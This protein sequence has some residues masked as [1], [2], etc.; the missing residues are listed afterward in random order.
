MDIPDLPLVV[1]MLA[2]FD[3]ERDPI[4]G[5]SLVIED[6]C[7]ERGLSASH[8]YNYLK[9]LD[10]YFSAVARQLSGIAFIGFSVWTSNFLTTLLFAMHLKGLGQAPFIVAGGPQLTESQASASL[11]LLSGLIDQVVLGEGEAT[12]LDVYASS[13]YSRKSTVAAVPGTMSMDGSG[14]LRRW[15]SRQLLRQEDIPVPT[16]DQIPLLSYQDSDSCT[17]PYHLSRGCTDKCVFCSEWKFWERFRPGSARGTLAGIEELSRRYG[18]RHIAFTDSLLNGHPGRLR[19]LCEGLLRSSNR[20]TWSGFMRAQMDR[21]TALLLRKAGCDVVFV[22]IESLS[23]DTLNLMNK[24]RTEDQNLEALRSFLNAGI[25]VVIGL[26]P[27]FPG[28]TRDA[29]LHT[30]NQVRDLQQQYPRG[31]RVNVEPFIVSPGQPIYSTLVASGL[32]GVGWEE[33]VLDIA[34]KYKEIT[35]S[36]LCRVEGIN[37]GV[38]RIGR[39]FIAESIQSDDPIR[40]D[41]FTYKASEDLVYHEF[42]FNHLTRGWF[43]ARAKGPAAWIYALIVNENERQQILD[44]QD[45]GDWRDVGGGS[46][47]GRLVKKIEADHDLKPKI[48]PHLITGGYSAQSLGPFTYQISPYVVGRQ[49]DWH[50]GNRWILAD[51]VTLMWDSLTSWQMRAV[52][53]LREKAL[54][55][56]SLARYISTNGRPVPEWRCND[57]LRRLADGGFLLSSEP[58]KVPRSITAAR[59]EIGPQP[60]PIA[61]LPTSG[62]LHIY[63]VS[64]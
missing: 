4:S 7:R 17:L 63:P 23:T 40:A 45:R 20:V 34:P 61:S 1:S 26:I 8:V 28:D 36:I 35:R 47:F 44:A 5:L 9:S 27:G 58:N 60:K 51:F 10:G 30:V 53:A 50:A 49:G 11:A 2:A 29:F 38:E 6:Y 21:D 13:D 55:G 22:G 57:L 16:F 52:R 18:A 42:E 32:S 12:L 43:L 64:K 3:Q 15:S 19:E 31:L 41:S 14:I 24:R 54:S 39:L 48:I 59:S 46:T 56:A 62:M 37:Q 33:K 25:Y